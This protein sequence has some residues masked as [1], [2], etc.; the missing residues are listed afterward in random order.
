MPIDLNLLPLPKY[1]QG[2]P[3]YLATNFQRLKDGLRSTVD[4]SLTWADQVKSAGASVWSPL[5]LQPGPIGYNVGA[6]TVDYT[7]LGKTVICV[8]QIIITGAGAA[9][10]LQLTPPVPALRT[11]NHPC[12][13]GWVFN[14]GNA[15][16][17]L[18]INASGNI[19]LIQAG[20]FYST[21]AV[22]GHSYNGLAVYQRA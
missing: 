7:L 6:S 16:G 17:P 10:A 13:D 18:A 9:S 4:F 12:G 2:I 20:G 15:I 11:S 22:A 3:R 8:F 21:A 14:G 5:L 19:A 1:E